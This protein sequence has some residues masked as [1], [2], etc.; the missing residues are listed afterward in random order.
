[1]TRRRKQFARS[2]VMGLF[3]LFLFCTGAWAEEVVIGFTGPL[4]GPGAGY[5]RDNL[6]GIKMACQ[7]VNK[8]GGIEIGGTTYTF[9]VESYDDMIDPTAAVNNARRLRSRS[10]ARV[11]FN[12]VFNTIAPLMEINEQKG[13]EFLLMAYTSDP[14]L[15]KIDNDLTVSTVPPFPAYVRAYS[16]LAWEKGWRKGAMVV[17]LGAYGDGW[18]KAFKDYWVNKMGGEIVAD[19][20]ANYY[21]ETDFSSQLSAALAKNPDFLLIGGPS[22]PTGLVIEQARNQGFEGGFML[23]DQA[24]MGYIADVVFDGDTSMMGE[25]IGTVRVKALPSQALKRIARQYKKQYEVTVTIEG[26]I[27]YSAMHLVF[28]AMKEAGTVDDPRAIKKA[29][30]R[31]LPQD[32]DVIPTPY[33]GLLHT[34]LLLPAIVSTVEDGAYGMDYQY[35]WWPRE[36]EACEKYTKMAPSAENI[37][38]EC[39]KLQGYLTD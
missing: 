7:E 36:Q 19:K 21:T 13:Q 26:L 39:I 20:P 31:V 4:S 33:Y 25:L 29:M 17:T 9:T 23:V 35:L 8:A 15:D 10:E 16:E 3:S 12:P 14:E 28:D 38:T 37:V 18:R 30:S 22:E 34:E 11:I 1:M 6:N 2:M 24:K 5:G 27:N 32:P